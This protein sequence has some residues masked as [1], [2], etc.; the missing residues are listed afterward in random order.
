MG[1]KKQYMNDVNPEKFVKQFYFDKVHEYIRY[2]TGKNDHLEDSI[3]PVL[4]KALN[5]FDKRKIDLLDLGCGFKCYI[6]E[7]NINQYI[8]ID[9]S[10]SLLL[11]H[12]LLGMNNIHLINKN[13]NHVDY[14]GLK[15]NVVL[16]VLIMN[17]IKDPS[18]FMAKIKRKHAFFFFAIPNPDYDEKFASISN[19]I[20]RLDVNDIELSYYNHSVECFLRA[21]GD[22]SRLKIEYT[23]PSHSK[24]TPPTYIC[25]YGEW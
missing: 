21:I 13:I 20:V 23:E 6:N 1:I 17:Y 5:M 8:G 4:D 7:N 3:V 9:I 16:G 19:N 22:T 14:S 10:K 24:E 25:F 18:V 12:E 11:R 15:Y 2:R